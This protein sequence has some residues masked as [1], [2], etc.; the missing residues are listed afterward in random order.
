MEQEDAFIG[1]PVRSLQTMLR[2][3][4]QTDPQLPVLIPDGIYGAETMRCVMAFQKQ[5]ALPQTGITDYATWNAVCAA[6]RAAEAD[7]LPPSPLQIDMPPGQILSEG[8]ESALVLLLQT[9]LHT[10]SAVYSN[11][12]DCTL[13]G[14]YDEETVR[15]VKAL[16]KACGFSETGCLDKALWQLLAGLYPQLAAIERTPPGENRPDEAPLCCSAHAE[17]ELEEAAL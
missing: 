14:R 16:Q 10:A 5:H 9:L 6:Y 15:S 17:T 3:L 4:A 1:K 13:C 7:L 2:M 11:L 12:P 8:Q